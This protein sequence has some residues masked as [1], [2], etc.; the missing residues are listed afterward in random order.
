MPQHRQDDKADAMYQFYQQG[1]SLSRVADAFGVTR[2]SVYKM[3]KRRGFVLRDR[4]APLPFVV[5]NGSKYTRRAT[6]YYAKTDGERSYLHRDIWEHH[7]GPIPPDHDI[8]HKDSDKANNTP[9]NLECLPK[10]EHA[11][12][13]STGRNQHSKKD[14]T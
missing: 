5:F 12:R 13:F 6:G 10:D 1:H 2:Q 3:F 9:S 8:H 14:G 11:R 7:Y 4:Q